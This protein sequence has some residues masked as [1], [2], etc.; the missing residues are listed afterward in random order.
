[1]TAIST[2]I[3]AG[4]KVI[5]P[6]TL[7]TGN[8]TSIN[9]DVSNLLPDEILVNLAVRKN[10]QTSGSQSLQFN[11]YTGHTSNNEW[12]KSIVPSSGTIVR[13]ETGGGG[14]SIIGQ[15]NPMGTDALANYL[16]F[17]RF[18][19]VNCQ[20]IVSKFYVW[21]EFAVTNVIATGE[22]GTEWGGDVAAFPVDRI[23]FSMGAA[24]FTTSS[25]WEILALK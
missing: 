9:F 25:W 1:M 24:T 22:S 10:N 13:L 17:Y 23:N 18:H 8:P 12:Q 2:V 4:Y 6:K 14:S 21:E 16:S 3:P 11:P 15:L 7:I 20:S 19:M 5:L